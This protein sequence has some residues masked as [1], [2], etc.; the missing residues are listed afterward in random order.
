MKRFKLSVLLI[1]VSA[2]IVAQTY[3][4]EDFS[5]NQMPPDG[6][7]IDNLAGQWS[8]HNGTNAGAVSPEGEFT[9]TNGI[10]HSRLIS[11]EIDLTGL[12]TIMVQFNQMFDWFAN[13]APITG[14]ATRSGGGDWNDVWMI[15]QTGDV[16]PE[17]VYIAVSNDDVGAEDFQICLYLNGDMYNVN[18]WY[19]DDIMVF[20]PLTLDAEMLS[21]TTPCYIGG[22][23]EIKGI[24]RSYGAT[25]ITSIDIEWEANGNIYSTN[26]S[27]LSLNFGDTYNFTCDDLFSLPIGSYELKVRIVNVNGISDDNPDNNQLIRQTCVVSNTV[28]KKPCL[29]EFTSSTCLTCAGFNDLFTPWLEDQADNITLIKYQM[30]WPPPGDIYYTEEG[31]I[32]RA[33]YD[34]VGIPSLFCNGSF[35]GTQGMVPMITEVNEAYNEALAQAGIMNIAASHILNGTEM[36]ISTTILPYAV[37]PNGIVHIIVFEYLTTGNVGSNGETE[38]VHVMMKM[39]PDANGTAVNLSDREPFHFNENLYLTETNVEEWNDLG[40]LVFVQDDVTKVIYQSA[41]S[42]ENG[43][44]AND[45]SLSS[46]TYDA[47]PIP[48]FNPTIYEYTIKIP[49][50]T[51]E[52]P[53]IGAISTDPDATVIIL[54]AFEIPGTTIIDVFAEDLSTQNTYS[55]HF[56]YETGISKNKNEL[57]NIFPNPTSGEVFIESAINSKVEVYN[58]AGA[59]VTSFS[60]F[61]SNLIDL[62]NLDEGVYFLKIIMENKTVINKKVSLLK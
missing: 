53:E 16:G 37:I 48:D 17:V 7:V 28:A 43:Y 26:I 30:N 42:I 1:A 31:G 9:T 45:A 41:Y 15:T 39:V 51:I 20:V 44:F 32:R 36:D 56:E 23:T 58:I 13:P 25:Q 38:F 19:I 8:L 62:Q 55:V 33:L 46:I 3:L 24:F 54:S 35:V 14:V 47:V 22:P 6:W 10:H 2:A 61:K 57:I 29:E 11:P 52:I 18:Y 21:I 50:G 27:G 49:Q 59:L 34:V 12:T 40:V 4:I 60:D 5:Q